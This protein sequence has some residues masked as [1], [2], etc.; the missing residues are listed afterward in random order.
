MMTQCNRMKLAFLVILATVIA[1]DVSLGQQPTGRELLTRSKRVLFLGDS[2]T[3]S[4]LY[5]AGFETWL[6]TELKDKAPRL[7]DCGLPSETVS[8]LS[9]DGHAGGQFPRP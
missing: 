3:A 6:V 4:G 7:I 1:G 9:E 5:V 2:I 8:R